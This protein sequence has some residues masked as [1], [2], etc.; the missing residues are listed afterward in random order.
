MYT[1]TEPISGKLR[2]VG[3]AALSARPARHSIGAS[4]TP[5]AARC[6][7]SKGRRAQ[8]P[9]S[10]QQISRG[11]ARRFLAHPSVCPNLAHRG[12]SRRRSN[13]VA[14]GAKRSFSEP[15]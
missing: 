13:S 15:L 12:I 5:T 2:T 10:F 8:G 4:L 14:I 11:P 6:R 7:R 9:K 3:L 1:S